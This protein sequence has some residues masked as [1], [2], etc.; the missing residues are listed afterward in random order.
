[1]RNH[2]NH[3]IARLSR[4]EPVISFKDL[5]LLFKPGTDLYLC[6]NRNWLSA[7]VVYKSFLTLESDYNMKRCERRFWNVEFWFLDTEGIRIQISLDTSKIAEFEGVRQVT[8]LPCYPCNF[9]DVQDKGERRQVLE[10]RGEKRYTLL[11]EEPKQMWYDGSL[12]S[13]H[14]VKV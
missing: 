4:P 3:A 10:K 6:Y 9:H 11:R 14:E 8:S 2:I 1:M 5:W 12:Y 7:G 13:T